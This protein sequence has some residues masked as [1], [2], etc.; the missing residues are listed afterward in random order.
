MNGYVAGAQADAATP[1]FDLQRVSLNF[2]TTAGFVAAQ[3]ANNVLVLALSTGRILKFD[4]DHPQEVINIEL[5]EQATEIGLIR[6]L[7]LDPSASHLIISTISGENFYLHTQSQQPRYLGRLKGA[8]IESIAWKP[9]L[10]TGSTGEILIGCVNGNVYETWIEPT[11]G[12]RFLRSQEIYFKKVYSPQDGPIIGLYAQALSTD[13]E[14]RR[15]LVATR[16]KLLH[17]ACRLRDRGHQQSLYGKLFETESLVMHDIHGTGQAVVPCLAVSPDRPSASPATGD[18]RAAERAYAWL[19]SDGVFRGNLA[20]SLSNSI[21]LDKS[22]QAF[23][24]PVFTSLRLPPMQIADDLDR[25]TQPQYSSMI[26]TQFHI[27]FL[28]GERINVI[29]RLDETIVQLQHNFGSD[30]HILGMFTD[31]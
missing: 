14:T 21:L 16:H 28:A 15:V 12:S 20:T 27:L 22:N 11:A 1:M 9:A 25:A 13:S 24:E 4:L 18:G 7:F 29:N 6:R 30:Q 5:P 26:L 8:Q 3:V 2:D 23:R 31:Q 19:S 10:P 17:F